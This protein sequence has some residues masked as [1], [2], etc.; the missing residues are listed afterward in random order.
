MSLRPKGAKRCQCR[1]GCVAWVLADHNRNGV[2]VYA[3]GHSPASHSKERNAKS[4]ATIQRMCAE[5]KIKRYS[6]AENVSKRPEVRAKIKAG[7]IGK[8][9]SASH[10]KAISDAKK[11]SGWKPSK[12]ML[13]ASIV[14]MRLHPQSAETRKKQGEKVRTL[15]AVRYWTG[16]PKGVPLACSG[17]NKGLTRETDVRIA[18]Y[19]D[20]G[21]GHKPYWGRFKYEG[22]HGTVSMR[23][24]WEVK[25]ALYLDGKG[26]DWQYEPKVFVLGHGNWRGASYWPDFYLPATKMYIEVKG[27]MPDNVRRKMAEFRR[28]YPKVKLKVLDCGALSRMGVIDRTSK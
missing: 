21:I 24:S 22:V 28:Q 19:G 9:K 26:V 23:S 11:A 1:K 8:P 3:R 5:G 25:Y 7:L 20:K 17:W 16:W 18:A 15:R 14:A 2:S 6:G 4:Q 13:D 12:A 27:W 10:R